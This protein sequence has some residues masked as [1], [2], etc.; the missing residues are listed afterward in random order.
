MLKI[1]MGT[2][3]AAA[4]ITSAGA[5]PS[6]DF[7][8]PVVDAPHPMITEVLYAVPPGDDGDAWPDGT[9]DATGDEF[10]ELYNPHD[11]TITLTGY[12]VSDRNRGGTGEFAFTFPPFRLG[13][14]E[15]VV[16]FNGHGQSF[17][18]K[19]VIGTAERAPR[20]ENEDMGC[21]VFHAGNDSKYTALSNRGDWVLLTDPEDQPVQVVHWGEF[22]EDVPSAPMVESIH[23]RSSGSVCRYWMGGPMVLHHQ[24][25]GRSM[26]PGEHPVGP[27]PEEARR[28]AEEAEAEDGGG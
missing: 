13:P 12:T 1:T 19:G 21:F 15:V 5:Q 4:G 20:D 9:R 2:A 22:D 10:V 28:M 23:E 18:G 3:V 26:S 8:K 24:I 6:T 27:S 25:D 17:A 14:G 16:I 7:E 11:R